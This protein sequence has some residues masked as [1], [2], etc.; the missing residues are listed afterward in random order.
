MNDTNVEN[1]VSRIILLL[2][3]L[4]F[5]LFTHSQCPA[6]VKKKCLNK[7]SPFTTNGQ[8]N[9]STVSAGQKISMKLTFSAGQDYRIVVCSEELLGDVTFMILDK[10][11]RVLF[12]SAQNDF[13]DFWDFKAISTQPLTVEVTV[14]PSQSTSSV[15]PSGCL[16]V[17]VGFK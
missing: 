10:S 6:F 4:T 8:V 16:S 12:D 17:L 14:P 15:L 1:S 7:I 5:P 3:I 9:T 2:L 13:P 11:K